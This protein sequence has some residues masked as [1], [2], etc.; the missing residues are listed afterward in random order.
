MN[1]NKPQPHLVNITGRL[2]CERF[3]DLL[4][5]FSN[6]RLDKFPEFMNARINAM[7]LFSDLTEDELV[8]LNLIFGLNIVIEE[9]L[10]PYR[11]D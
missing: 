6:T 8:I 5:E 1:S 9:D 2:N 7:S 3:E 11:H 4:D 10:H